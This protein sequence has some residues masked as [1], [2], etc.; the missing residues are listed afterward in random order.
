MANAILSRKSKSGGTSIPNVKIYY[1]DT[2][3]MVV[4]K[5]DLQTKGI[6]QMAQN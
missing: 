4:A 2:N 1:K 5:T 3:G 6:E